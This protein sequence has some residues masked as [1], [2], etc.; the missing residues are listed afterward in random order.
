MYHIEFVE[1]GIE[2]C[3]HEEWNVYVGELATP[4][5]GDLGST[6]VSFYTYPM[7]NCFE[8]YTWHA[9]TSP[10]KTC[11]TKSSTLC[12]TKWST[13][14]LK[15]KARTSSQSLYPKSE[16]KVYLVGIYNKREPVS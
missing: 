9:G 6:G 7:I 11:R 5:E 8:S 15:M 4:G 3:V 2:L 16:Q 14:K 10:G 12:V 1:I 13:T